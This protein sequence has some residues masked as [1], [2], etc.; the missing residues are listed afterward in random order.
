M[1]YFPY[2]PPNGFTGTYH[3][4]QNASATFPQ[5]MQLPWTQMQ[6]AMSDPNP[7]NN[8]PKAISYVQSDENALVN[9]IQ[10]VS[11]S[12][13][14]ENSQKVKQIIDLCKYDD[15]IKAID[16]ELQKKTPN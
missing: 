6:S 5:N 7:P 11:L 14:E 16:Q 2:V 3:M 4:P 8:A 15:L 9:S 12:N 1:P 13:N 10:N